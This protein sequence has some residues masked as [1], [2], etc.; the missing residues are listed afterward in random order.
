MLAAVPARVLPACWLSV[1]LLC[2]LA[3]GTPPVS[4]TSAQGSD[5]RL[6]V[7]IAADQF[8]AD[9]LTRFRAEYRQGLDTLLTRGAV[10]TNAH[11]EHS[12]TYT[13]PGHATM[14]TGAHPSASGIIANAWYDRDRGRLVTSVA[15]DE[16]TTVGSAR[17]ETASPRRLLVP[18]LVEAVKRQ[19]GDAAP[20]RPK[21]IGISAKARSAI[22]MVG[23]EADAAYWFSRTMF[24]TSSWYTKELPSWV[25]AFNERQPWSEYAGRRWTFGTSDKGRDMPPKPGPRLNA[26][27]FESSFGNEV[28]VAFAKDVVSHERLG[29]R[30]VTD[31]LAVSLSSNDDVGH[32]YGPDS[33]EV[34][35]VTV[36]TDA[37]VA[38]LLQHI[39]TLVGLGHVVVAF[40]ADH[41]VSPLPETTSAQGRSAGRFVGRVQNEA[42]EA[43]LSAKF[44]AGKW[45]LSGGDSVYLNHSLITER[46]LDAADVRATAAAAIATVPHVAHVYTREQLLGP[47]PPTDLIGRRAA[48]SYH[49]DRSGDVEV[50]LEPHWIRDNSG[51]EHGSPYDDDSHVP[52]IVMGPGVRAGTYQEPVALNDLAPTLAHLLG[53]PAPSASAGRVLTEALM[54]PARNP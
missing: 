3:L 31:I 4:S 29:Q 52:L 33:P 28:L 10:F 46:K 19:A 32:E 23:R 48:N 54:S 22:L 20:E 13:A 53:V 24:V 47:A 14:L 9:F 25:T 17:G 12:R 16:V 37:A 43:A 38:D 30:G 1:L 45:V 34:H 7:L 40:T 27:V 18:T 35:D 36:K 51:A 6:V 49:G 2:A 8:R 50:V 15:D 26:A 11:V 21:V 44:G 5:I 39:D 42:V 41:G